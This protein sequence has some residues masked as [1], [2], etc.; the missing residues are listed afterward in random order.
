[1]P[2]ERT[3]Y[4]VARGQPGV[5]IGDDSFQ[6]EWEFWLQCC[7]MSGRLTPEASAVTEEDALAL[8]RVIEKRWSEFGRQVHMVCWGDEHGRRTGEFL[9][10]LK[11]GGFRVVDSSQQDEALE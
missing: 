3:L 11:H 2:N 9:K 6:V 1:M 8:A 4:L 10:F 5:R 7:L